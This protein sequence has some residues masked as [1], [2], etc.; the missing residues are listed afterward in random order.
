M[1]LWIIPTKQKNLMWFLFIEPLIYQRVSCG[2]TRH[3][4]APNVGRISDGD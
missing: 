3:D 2:I 1:L 4:L